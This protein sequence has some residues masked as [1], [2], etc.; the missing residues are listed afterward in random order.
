[1]L[2]GGI[3]FIYYIYE[4]KETMINEQIDE[5]KELMDKIFDILSKIILTELSEKEE[6]DAA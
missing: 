3:L 4:V 5:T 1:M 6:E 2:S